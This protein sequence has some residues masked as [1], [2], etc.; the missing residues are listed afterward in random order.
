MLDGGRVF[1][2]HPR[3]GVYG[4]LDTSLHQSLKRHKQSV[5]HKSAQEQEAIRLA[6]ER[7]GGVRQAFRN[8]VMIQRKAVIGA[9]HLVYWLAKKE[10]AQLNSIL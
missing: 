3:T 1:Y 2:A 4:N 6:S 7:D 10:V 5:M 8:R 9:L